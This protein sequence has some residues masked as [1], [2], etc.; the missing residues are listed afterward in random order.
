MHR[1]YELV[2]PTG[3]D[4]AELGRVLLA[5]WLE[6]YPNPA[7]GV[8]ERWIRAQRGDSATPEGA[9]RWREFIESTTRDPDRS[10]CRVV[11]R[12]PQAPIVGFLCG[13]REDPASGGHVTL[14]PMY[15]LAAAQGLGIG[16]QMM[17]EFL[18]WAGPVPVLLW[19]TSYNESAVRFY[20]HYG[21]QPTGE[22][23]LW[24]GRLPN[25][26]M[27][28]AAEVAADQAGWRSGTAGIKP[29]RNV[30]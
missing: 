20:R 13:R 28:R 30:G 10:F 21:F 9:C 3:G 6:T 14:G 5:A 19:V 25:E 24:Q 27:R 11:R 4:A 1:Q 16:R 17:A 18:D 15:L 26:R 23:E 29:G 12:G 8:D 7:A 22:R 2:E